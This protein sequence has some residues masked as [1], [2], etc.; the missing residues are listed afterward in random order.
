MGA[1]AGHRLV[2]SSHC[3]D[4]P[5]EVDQQSEKGDLAP[6]LLIHRDLVRGRFMP[7][8][9]QT[10]PRLLGS[11]EGERGAATV[12]PPRIVGSRNRS[13]VAAYTLRTSQSEASVPMASSHLSLIHDSYLR[14][15]TGRQ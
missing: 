12:Q 11:H 14:R 3:L 10:R 2:E 1:C 4:H 15:P 6:H 13:R 7:K 8:V 5:T 9:G